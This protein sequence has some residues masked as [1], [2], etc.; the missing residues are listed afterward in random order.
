M[1]LAPRYDGPTILSVDGQPSDQLEPLTRQ[2]RRMQA[3]LSE[4]ADDEWMTA[5]RCAAWTVRDVV[6]HLVGVNA[7]W[8]ASVVA[9]LAGSP[10]RILGGGF[11]PVTTPPLDGQP[12]GDV[13][14][15]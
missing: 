6:A 13:D 5:S 10:T 7:F 8:H 12:D 9:G 11:D 1:I 3:M 4:L 15:S 14:C 2:R